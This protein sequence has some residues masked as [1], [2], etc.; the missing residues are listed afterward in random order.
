MPFIVEQYKRLGPIFRVRALNQEIVILAGPEANIFVTQQGMDKFSSK[1]AW[2][3]YGQ[4]F[5]V[6]VQMQNIDGE[7]H[8][9]MRKL[10]KP[11]YSAGSLMADIPLMIEIE[12]KVLDNT[13]TGK[14]TAALYLFRL[15]VTEQ[16]GKMLANHA[17]GADLEH[18]VTTIRTSLNVHVN[19][20]SPSLL[21]RTPSFRRAKQRY[22]QVGQEIVAKHRA[23]SRAKADLVDTL[24][25][26]H[27]SDQ[28]NDVLGDEAQ[29]TYAALGPF[30]AGLD[31][32]AN[33]CTFMLYALLRHPAVLA[34]CVEEAD[35]LF[36]NGTPTLAQLRAPGALH[37]AMMETL[38]LYSIAPVVNRSA[39]KT[40]EFAGCQVKQGQNLLLASTTAHFLPEIFSDPYKFDITRYQEE[41]K[42]HKKRGA[43]APFG[44]GTHLCLG[45]G[46]AETQIVLVMAALLHMAR[47][48]WV[49]P[50]AKLPMKIDP[51]PTLGPKF[52]IRIAE[53][54]Q[55]TP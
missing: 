17:P 21:L 47:I 35:Q 24:L 33:E 53:R 42:E 25:D 29:L 48:E 46:A 34:Q 20:K 30:V 11:A 7:A 6:D 41:R 4:E 39:A 27:Q 2:S 44:I 12:R 31:T 36:A 16:L 50:R 23:T 8:T 54:R 9:R 5:G 32:V 40:F 37:Y 10:L 52:K 49:N 22:L 26:A 18:I 51:T 38:R 43:Y 13:P 55:T 45:A 1:E 15:I 19:K 14:E 3:A 28:Y